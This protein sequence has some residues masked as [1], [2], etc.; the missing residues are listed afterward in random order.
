MQPQGAWGDDPPVEP[1]FPERVSRDENRFLARGAE[2]AAPVEN[3]V[4]IGGHRAHPHRL[5]GRLK[6]GAAAAA[7]AALA[8]EE[9]GVL[10]RSAL[11]PGDV[12][13]SAVRPV[14]TPVTSR[15]EAESRGEAMQRRIKSLLD[16]GAFDYVEPDYLVSVQQTAPSDA[17]F[18][19]GR[20]W[21]L[22]NTGQNGGVAGA[23]I[24]AVRAWAEAK[25]GRSSS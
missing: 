7:A 19:D 11:S 21:A 22:R 8:S 24:D 20:L 18:T 10:R 2:Q 16:S 1:L 3:S 12:T 6:D 23:D 25:R 5:L 13:L 14:L 17:A 4:V 9:M 15:A